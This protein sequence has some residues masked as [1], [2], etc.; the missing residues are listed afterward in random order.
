[1]S[2]D[3]LSEAAAQANRAGVE[4]DELTWEDARALV[5]AAAGSAAYAPEGYTGVDPRNGEPAIF[6]ERRARRPHDNGPGGSRS[7]VVCEGRI[8]PI[9]DIAPLSAGFTFINTNLYPIVAPTAAVAAPPYAPVYGLHLLQWTSSLHGADW[10]TL[11][12]SDRRIALDRLA[13]LETRL[14]ALDGFPAPAER[15]YV[16]IIKNVGRSVGG[17]LTHGHQQIAL[18]NVKPR[19]VAEDEHCAAQTGSGFGPYMRAANPPELTVFELEH[20]RMIVPYFMR[21][22][23]DMQFVLFDPSPMYLSELT[24]G[25]RQDLGHALA[26]GMR[27]LSHVLSQLGREVAYNIV[28]HTG[29]PGGL[30]LELLPYSQPEGGFERLGLSACQSSPPAA[31]RYLAEVAAALSDSWRR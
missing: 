24:A 4:L 25:Q 5:G 14:L 18:S 12:A 9:L 16:S 3:R 19:R 11:P 28:F 26:A 17:S 13:A 31:A 1:M 7:C 2:G 29:V 15:R 8:T 21:R 22:P 20:G 6:N 30:Y 27:M 23:F 10:D